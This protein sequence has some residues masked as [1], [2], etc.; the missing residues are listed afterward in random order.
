MTHEEKAREIIKHFVHI[1]F[2]KGTSVK[3]DNSLMLMIAS[4]FAEAEKKAYEK[5]REEGRNEIINFPNSERLQGWNEA[6]E[7]ARKV[8]ESNCP[9]PILDGVSCGCEATKI[10]E[11]IQRLKRG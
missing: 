11:S 3:V 2:D 6:I 1:N 5:G 4:A 9:E 10:A 8:A 7:A